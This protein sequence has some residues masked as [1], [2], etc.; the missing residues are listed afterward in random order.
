MK[1]E[2]EGELHGLI[3]R[4]M[5]DRRLT[6]EEGIECLKNLIDI[7]EQEPDREKTVEELAEAILR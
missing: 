5:V 1:P 6:I 3:M 4:H 7:F 2:V